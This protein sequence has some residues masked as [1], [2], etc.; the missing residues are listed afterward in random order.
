MSAI[1]DRYRSLAADLTTRIAAV[2]A[3][4]WDSPSPCEG[5][6][7]RDVLHHLLE[8]HRT[9]PA[10]AGVIVPAGPSADDDPLG[11]WEAARDGVQAVLDDPAQAHR[12]F[13]GLLGPTTV[14]ESLDRFLC[15]D[16][17]VHGWDIARATG[18][19]E[20]LD[21]AEV[22]RVYT[23]ALALGDTIRRPEVCGPPVPVPADADPQTRLLAHLGRRP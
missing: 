10:M 20:H 6:T 13:D 14:Q 18:T 19:D 9:L 21:P 5:W 2:P 17:L 7:A 8:A 3:D 23:D 11:A 22:D 12:E 4:R 1:A 16:L 15:L